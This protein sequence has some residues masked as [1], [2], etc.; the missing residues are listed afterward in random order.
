MVAAAGSDWH[1]A[2]P[3]RSLSSPS[4]AR[5]DRQSH[6]ESNYAMPSMP[7][8]LTLT[9]SAAAATLLVGCA[10]AP[11][12]PVTGATPAAAAGPRCDKREVTGSRMARCDDG[13]RTR[14]VDVISGEAIRATGMPSAGAGGGAPAN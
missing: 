7:A 1:D 10:S 3:A 11:A 5:R 9:L 12:A 2:R 13:A 4:A 14:D 8:C 6:P